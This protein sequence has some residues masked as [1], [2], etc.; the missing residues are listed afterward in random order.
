[1]RD[2]YDATYYTPMPYDPSLIFSDIAHAKLKS[3]IRFAS[4]HAH[5]SNSAQTRLWAS[6]EH[7]YVPFGVL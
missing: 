3:S 2:K 4:A 7:K 6:I 5:A 1:M